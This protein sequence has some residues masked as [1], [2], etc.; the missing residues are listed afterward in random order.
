M[1]GGERRQKTEDRRQKVRSSGVQ[2]FRSSGVQEFRSSGVQ[3]FRSSG[4]QEFGRHEPASITKVGSR[5]RRPLS[6][7]RSSETHDGCRKVA[8]LPG[9]MFENSN[10]V[11]IVLCGRRKRV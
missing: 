5:A 9:T 2:E 4:V 8:S 7:S 6:S 1:G 11:N 10:E 3:E